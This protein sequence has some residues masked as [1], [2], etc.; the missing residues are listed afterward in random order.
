MDLETARHEAL[1]AASWFDT[2]L[3]RGLFP[4]VRRA[5]GTLDLGQVDTLQAAITGD[6]GRLLEATYP[7]AVSMLRRALN[8]FYD[9][10]LYAA[11]DA[12]REACSYLQPKSPTQRPPG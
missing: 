6:A 8:L 7:L 12:L 9:S 2:G 10:R 5:D 1:V 3:D 4:T 11:Q